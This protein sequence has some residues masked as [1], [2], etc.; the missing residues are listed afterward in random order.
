MHPSYSVFVGGLQRFFYAIGGSAGLCLC[1]IE[2][3]QAGA[4]G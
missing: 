1:V 2:D 4:N 3:K